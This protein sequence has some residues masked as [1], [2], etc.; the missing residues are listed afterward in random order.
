MNMIKR[1]LISVS[2]KRGIADFAKG[3]SRLGIEIISTGGTAKLLKAKGVKVIDVSAYTG[4]PEIMGGRVKTLHPLIHGGILFRR[5]LGKD[6]KEAEKN[7]IKPIDLVVVNLYHFEEAIKKDYDNVDNAI[8]N[9]DIGGPSLIR[10]AAKNYRH[11]AVVADPNDYKKVLE[12]IKKGKKVS[13]ETRQKLAAKAFDRTTDYDSRIDEYLNDKL[14]HE[15]IIRLSNIDGKM[16]RYG[17]N[18]HQKGWFYRDPEMYENC[19]ANGKQLHGKALSF[20]NI[21]DLDS[22][23]ELVKEF[24]EP[25]AAIIKHTNPCG[26]ATRKTIEEA[27]KAAH[28]V[29]PK[30]AFGCVI[31]LN[32]PCNLAAA[33]LIK[34]FFVEAVVAP[35]FDKGALELLQQKKNIRL[36]EVGDLIKSDKGFELKKVVGGLLFQTRGF[37]K[38]AKKDLKVVTKRKPTDK[39]IEDMLYAWKINEHVK[40][41]AIVL[42]KDK[43]VVGVGAGQMSR[44]DSSII[45]ARKAGKRAKGD[46]LSSD[47]FFP[48]RDGVDAAA[49]VGVTAI[50]QP[51]GSIRDQEVI[52]AANEHNI[53]MVFTG[54]RLFRH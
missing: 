13:L 32:K 36:I 31:A 19:I 7:R 21:L 35:F 53:A 40:S 6:K 43:T 9:I 17:E 25:T 11:V 23:L 27:Y 46:A 33:E 37:P 30:S 24:R 39:E 42:V 29:D 48:F 8:E 10:A 22:A 20:N 54:V 52:D 34:P 3:L 44:V 12:E 16:L 41:N 47:A 15:K 50:I 38:V 5:D 2:D 1:A 51:G 28:E 14:K 26:A 18:P 45:A 49:K 4:F